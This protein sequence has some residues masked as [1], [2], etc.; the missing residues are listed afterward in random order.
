VTNPEPKFIRLHAAY[1]LGDHGDSGGP[2]F[3]GNK[4]YGVISGGDSSGGTVDLIYT[5]I[6]FAIGDLGL[7]LKTK[8]S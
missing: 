6:N 4:A 2:V 1:D 5:A 7:L 3:W 8:V